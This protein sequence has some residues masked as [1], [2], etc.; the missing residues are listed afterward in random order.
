MFEIIDC[1]QGSPEWYAARLGL[2]TASELSTVM[3]KGKDGGASLTRAKYLRTLAG[4]RITGE[5]DP[6]GFSNAHMERG[7]LWEAEARDL[8]AFEYDVEPRQVGFLRTAIA[9]ASPDSLIGDDG[10]LEIKTALR[11]I[12][13]ERLQR[14]GLPPEHKA[15]VQGCLWIT[16]RQ[17]WDFMSYAPKLPALYVRVYPEPEYHAQ[18]EKA[19]IAFNEELANLV[20]SLRGVDQFRSAA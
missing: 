3:A 13:I 20:S 19:V 12:Q 15:Q 10:G 8:Y 2:V 6:D 14:G 9:G 18:I 16:K 17:W 11:H 7:K 1:E 5:P 4:E